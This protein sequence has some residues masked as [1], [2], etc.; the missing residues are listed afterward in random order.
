[1]RTVGAFSGVIPAFPDIFAFFG[2]QR[3]SVIS[4]SE[5]LFYNSA[6]KF[7]AILKANSIIVAATIIFSP[8]DS[9]T[10]VVEQLNALSTRVVIICSYDTDLGNFIFSV[11]DLGLLDAGWAWLLLWANSITSAYSSFVA[12]FESGNDAP[13]PGISIFRG[14][15]AIDWKLGE[16]EDP[17]FIQFG[18]EVRERLP[19]FGVTP[20]PEE[21]GSLY[22]APLYDSIFLYAQAI[23]YLVQSGI[24]P[25]NASALFDAAT[26]ISFDGM[27]G[28]VDLTAK[29]DRLAD[30][31]VPVVR[32]R[33]M[34][35]LSIRLISGIIARDSPTLAACNQTSGPSGRSQLAYP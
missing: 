15:I 2:W 34:P 31:T 27:S 29:G 28:R 5:P 3:C 1:M 18:Q 20:L 30:V 33:L 6:N 14:I 24:S 26:K 21:G 25:T 12:S 23:D 19:D 17:E 35:K 11:N 32:T 10:S 22:S 8:G 16:T 7:S 9:L 4:S 13:P